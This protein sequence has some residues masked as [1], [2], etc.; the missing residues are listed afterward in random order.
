VSAVE[1]PQNES[2]NNASI[3][4]LAC[5]IRHWTW[6]DQARAQFERELA[7]GWRYDED[8]PGDQLFG[9]Y[10]HWCAL[11]CSF[12]EAAL[13][14]GL[15]PASQLDALRPDLEACLP[16]LRACRQVLVVIPAAR[17]ARPRIA[18]LL[19]DDE[20]LGRLR[21]VHDAFGDALR[22]EQV[23][24]QLDFLDVDER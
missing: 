14:R 16:D 5:L 11:L 7:N 13:D 22:Q 19:R 9:S 23:S 24:R 18:D 1:A 21:R 20:T 15:L 6:A 3:N 10:Y 2:L 12:G 17:E 8:P 4:R